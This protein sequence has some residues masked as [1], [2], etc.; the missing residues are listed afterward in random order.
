M[1]ILMAA[2]SSWNLY[3][4]RK[5]LREKC[6]SANYDLTLVAPE[7]KY[8]RLFGPREH[9]SRWF[10]QRG[11]M[12]PLNE[13][14]SILDLLYKVR[15]NRPDIVH[16][17][18]L[19]AAIYVSVATLGYKD[20]IAIGSITGLGHLFVSKSRRTRLARSII[21]KLAGPLLNRKG[22]HLILQ[23]AA[24][25]E[26]LARMGVCNHENTTLIRGSGVDTDYYKRKGGLSPNNSEHFRILFPARII[27]EKGI[28]EVYE[29]FCMLRNE[30]KNLKL[31]V[32]GQLERGYRSAID[33]SLFN[34]MSA[35]ENV[36]MLGHCSNMLE[37]YE[38]GDLVVLPSWREGLSKALLES[39]SMELPIITTDVPGCKDIIE[40]GVSGI[41]VPPHSSHSLALAIDF[42]IK[43]R[44]LM[45]TFGK[46]ARARVIS[47]FTASIVNTEI[48]EFYSDKYY[49]RSM[50]KECHSI[51]LEPKK[52]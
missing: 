15:S 46:K 41:L 19:K 16:G 6:I 38:K 27:R 17:F 37:V 51:E 50:R 33:R 39:A 14:C 29:S 22:F 44:S 2:T 20:C 48:I 42:A 45:H 4:Y 40:N 13:I 49:Q 35:D 32:A 31:I 23:N 28:Y 1:K 24:D 10:L 18:T 7:D 21:M 12:N 11:S 43:N 52:K 3:H 8:S 36:E 25:Y 5:T 34:T 26:A 9:Y 47:Q 30:Y